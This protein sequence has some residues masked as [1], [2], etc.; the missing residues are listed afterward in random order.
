MD[1]HVGVRVRDNV[2]LKAKTTVIL[3]LEFILLEEDHA[4]PTNIVISFLQV[5]CV[6]VVIDSLIDIRRTKIAKKHPRS[7]STKGKTR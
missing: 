3:I 6:S 5:V 2:Y 1:V 4:I 7:D